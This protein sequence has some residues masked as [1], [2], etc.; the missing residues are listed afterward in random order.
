MNKYRIKP[1]GVDNNTYY[2]IERRVLLFFWKSYKT[3]YY[4]RGKM[5]LAQKLFPT[6]QEAQS[7]CN[8]LNAR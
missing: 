4:L 2:V 8:D 6:R 3:A 7:W 5:M 1:I